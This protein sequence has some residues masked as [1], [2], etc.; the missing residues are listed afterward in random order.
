M[1]K[2]T[3]WFEVDRDGLAK[4]LLRRGVSFI[5]HE[6]VAN[7][8]DAGG[9]RIEVTVGGTGLEVSD[10]G[11]GFADLSDSYVLFGKSRRA[12]DAEKRGRFD[13]GEK[14]VLAVATSAVIQSTGGTVVFDEH[15]R[16]RSS[17]RTASGTLVSLRLRPKFCKLDE[18]ADACRRI[19]LPAGVRLVLNGS[20]LPERSPVGLAIDVLPTVIADADGNLRPS[21]RKATV[22][23]Y[24]PLPGETP[25]VYELGIP[26]CQH[27]GK[28]HYNVSQK[29]PLNLDRDGVPAAL[30]AQL[31]ALAYE[32]L[33]RHVEDVTGD[34]VK[35]AVERPE[36]GQSATTAYVTAKY[37]D[38][39]VSYDPSDPEANKLAT[40]GGYTVVPGGAES[41]KVWAKAR[42]YA[43]ILPAGQV[44]P[45]PKPFSPDGTPLKLIDANDYTE[46]QKALVRYAQE[47]AVRVLGRSV[48]V[49]LTKDPH[50]NFGA[51]YGD[52]RLT[53]NVR[54]LDIEDQERVDALLIHEFAHE[55]E[56]DHLSDGYHKA[57]CKV[58]AKLAEAVRAAPQFGL[59]AVRGVSCGGVR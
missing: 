20:P 8:I 31:H 35:T 47:F 44:T 18:I 12:G 1:K 13:L 28:Y 53:I 56:S 29:I 59:G 25:D 10:D 15:G 58:G 36:V 41:G 45:S 7:A 51:A 37:G 26:V 52:R 40:V 2:V 49:S 38:K 42:E 6:L 57:C 14:L 23:F 30:L 54:R 32:H 27:D 48:S 11:E 5:V 39:R 22:E 43:A 50:W 34:W 19:I 16:H 33:Y 4:V 3:T 9:K 46:A 21:K 17:K 55:Y 24:E